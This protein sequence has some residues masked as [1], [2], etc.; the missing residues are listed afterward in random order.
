MGKPGLQVSES[1]GGVTDSKGAPQEIAANPASRARVLL[2][3]GVFTLVPSA[4]LRQPKLAVLRTDSC[5]NHGEIA[6]SRRAHQAQTR[7]PLRAPKTRISINLLHP[8]TIF[9]VKTSVALGLLATST[10]SPALMTGLVAVNV[11]TLRGSTETVASRVIQW[12]GMD[13]RCSRS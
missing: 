11:E 9:G 5:L 12:T 4:E 1:K 10:G 3:C 6:D 2:Y 7:P 8:S 13:R